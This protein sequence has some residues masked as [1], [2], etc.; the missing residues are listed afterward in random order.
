MFLDKFLHNTELP[1]LA[2]SGAVSHEDAL[3]Q[4]R[5]QYD[6]FAE[7]RRLQAEA[8]ADTRYMDDLRTSAQTLETERKKQPTKKKRKP[9]S[10]G[11]KSLNS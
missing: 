7:R 8:E 4:A 2:G 5:R 11:K 9:G 3:E 6:E 1:V 10:E